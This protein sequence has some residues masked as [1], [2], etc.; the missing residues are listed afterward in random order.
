MRRAALPTG[1]CSGRSWENFDSRCVNG[2][3]NDRYKE[4]YNEA[5]RARGWA[6]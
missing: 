2:V 1:S 4:A 5:R 6:W 3:Q